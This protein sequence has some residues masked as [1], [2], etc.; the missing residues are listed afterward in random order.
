ME[1]LKTV[2]YLLNRVPSKAI[3]KT[4]FELWT[5]RKPSMRHLH[6]WSCLAKARIHMK[7]NWILKPLVV[8]LL[9]IQQNPKSIGFTILH[10]V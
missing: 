6:V 7:G 4:H 3:S 1:A 8:T 10:I 5:R 2:V 9:V